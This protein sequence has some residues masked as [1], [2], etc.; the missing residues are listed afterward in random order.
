MKAVKYKEAGLGTAKERYL[1]D[2]Y[3]EF[4][5]ELGRCPKFR[6]RHGWILKITILAVKAEVPYDT[7]EALILKGMENIAPRDYQPSEIHNAYHGVLNAKK[8]GGFKRSGQG[9]L[10]APD[11]DKDRTDHDRAVD[12]QFQIAERFAKT[13]L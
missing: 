12:P 4:T 1:E 8:K 11:Y 9:K 5:E 6:D 10:N 3:L 13:S 7:A 2:A